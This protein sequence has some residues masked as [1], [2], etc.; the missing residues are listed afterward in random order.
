M[1]AEREEIVAKKSKEIEDLKLKYKLEKL[2][3]LEVKIQE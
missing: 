3:P 2:Q 1:N